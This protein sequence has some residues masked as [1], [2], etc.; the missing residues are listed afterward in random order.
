MII[1]NIK[2][3]AKLIAMEKQAKPR[4]GD[5]A[6]FQFKDKLEITVTKSGDKNGHS[7]RA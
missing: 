2:K 7:Q 5:L 1:D 4:N 6:P 3:T